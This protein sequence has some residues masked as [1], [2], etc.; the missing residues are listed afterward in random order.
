MSHTGVGGLSLGGGYGFLNGVHG[1]VVDNIVEIE[2][3]LASGEIVRANEKQNEDLFWAVRC[4]YLISILSYPSQT[5]MKVLGVFFVLMTDPS[6]KNASSMLKSTQRSR[7]QLRHRNPAHLPRTPPSRS[8]VR[9]PRLRTQPARTT[10]RPRKRQLRAQERQQQR[11]ARLRE[12]AS[13]THA[14]DPRRPVL[15]R[16]RESCA[17]AL[18]CLPCPPGCGDGR[19]DDVVPGTELCLRCQLWPWAKEEHERLGVHATARYRAG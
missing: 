3:V 10:R 7:H 4:V 6:F 14:C 8:M 2:M 11:L 15:Q 19:R 16:P 5:S 1:L 17:L 9:N 13:L 18:R 12:P